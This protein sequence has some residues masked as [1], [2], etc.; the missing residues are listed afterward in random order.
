MSIEDN[1]TFLDSAYTHHLHCH[2]H[3][4]KMA[5]AQEC[6]LRAKTVNFG[7]AKGVVGSDEKRDSVLDAMNKKKS[8]RKF[9]R[10]PKKQHL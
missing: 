1:V 5:A 4:S 6:C 8:K 10:D 3:G 2:H 9:G 7:I